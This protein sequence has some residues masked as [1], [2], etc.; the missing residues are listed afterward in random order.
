[1]MG[2]M[3]MQS[4]LCVHTKYE[5]MEEIYLY[6]IWEFFSDEEEVDVEIK[7]FNLE[8]EKYS[9]LVGNNSE[10][11]NP[12]FMGNFRLD[13]LENRAV[14]KFRQKK[15]YF[16]RIVRR[17][18][19]KGGEDEKGFINILGRDISLDKSY[20]NLFTFNTIDLEKMDLSVKIE[21]E[22]GSV[23]EIKRQKFVVKNVLGLYQS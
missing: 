7:K 10:I 18:G 17:K 15:I 11:N 13:E 19:E 3:V 20:I 1:S 14:R 8:Y 16:L 6:P 2:V 9:E 23:D 5:N 22:D 12:K 21:K 4:N